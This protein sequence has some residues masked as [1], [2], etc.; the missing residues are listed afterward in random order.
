MEPNETLSM[1]DNENKT[2]S[3]IT[4]H[5]LMEQLGEKRKKKSKS[6]NIVFIISLITISL[7]I[8]GI[9]LLMSNEV[10]NGTTSA[11]KE[12]EWQD[13][14]SSLLINQTPN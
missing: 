13:V 12:N 1:F 2:E 8:F 4:L 10:K 9:A 11:I 6:K 7:N 5:Q 14:Y 3:P